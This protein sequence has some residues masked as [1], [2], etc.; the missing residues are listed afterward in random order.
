MKKITTV[1]YVFAVLALFVLMTGCGSSKKETA[2]SNTVTDAD[3][4][5]AA[6]GDVDADADPE[7][8]EMDADSDG[9]EDADAGNTESDDD[10]GTSTDS[11]SFQY[12]EEIDY[13]DYSKC[14]DKKYLCV[15]GVAFFCAEDGHWQPYKGGSS[16]PD[17]DDDADNRECFYGE[18][19]CLG[20][21]LFFCK[22][23]GHWR[24]EK[25][26][27]KDSCHPSGDKCFGSECVGEKPNY[28]CLASGTPLDPYGQMWEYDYY[29]EYCEYGYFKPS[30]DCEEECDSVTGKCKNEGC[31]PGEYQCVKSGDENHSMYCRLGVW[32]VGKVCGGE[33][34]QETGRCKDACPEVDGNMWSSL[35]Y[36]R[37]DW[38]KAASYCNNLTE[39]GYSDWRMPT[40]DELRTLIQNCPQT[41]SGGECQVSEKNGKLSTNDWY[42]EGSCSC[43]KKDDSYYSKLEDNSGT[44]L[45]SSSVRS[46]IP[47]AAWLIL[48]GNAM[49][50]SESKDVSAY[51]F[52][53]VRCVR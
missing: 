19:F 12:D 46:D 42:P 49:I 40:I 53:S 13:P 15:G 31:V 30:Q 38:H 22:T 18:Y 4:D 24:L 11:E 33:C 48:V 29:S 26:C 25:D 43:D 1:F 44:L 51:G 47:N 27:Y 28:T 9:T 34:D 17:D 3:N 36:V 5:I 45:W 20:G 10:S 50:H 52:T 8:S 32:E 2:E 35:G 7:D 21:K 16:C 39:C 37:M 6:D 23:N 14:S 41:E